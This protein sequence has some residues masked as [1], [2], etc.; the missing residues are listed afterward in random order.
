M[1]KEKTI[2]WGLAL[3]SQETLKDADIRI[4]DIGTDFTKSTV[5]IVSEQGMNV[6]VTEMSIENAREIGF[7]NLDALK[8]HL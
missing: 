5:N 2:V 7:I 1:A 3:F 6:K 8:G 4:T